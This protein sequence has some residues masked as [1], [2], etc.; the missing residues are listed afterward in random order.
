MVVLD[1]S[2]E[3][4]PLTTPSPSNNWRALPGPARLELVVLTW[5]PVEQV[6]PGMFVE[7]LGTTVAA[8]TLRRQGY[9]DLVGPTPFRPRGINDGPAQISHPFGDLV[10]V[11]APWEAMTRRA[12][13]RLSTG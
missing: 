10:E 11:R 8:L 9:V 3:Y 13:T 1:L 6:K 12:S 5:L 2:L 7:S 4:G